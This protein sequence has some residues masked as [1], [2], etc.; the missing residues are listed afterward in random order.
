MSSEGFDFKKFISD[1]TDTVLKPKE[2][3]ESMKTNGG[4]AEPL[5]K[6]LIYGV[7]AGFIYLIWGFL[8]FGPGLGLFGGAV[9]IMG[10]IW[11]I[12]GS[13]IGLFI[14]AVIILVL[15]AIARGNTDFEACVRVSASIM[16][17]LPVIAVC[18]VLGAI[19]FKLSSLVMLLIN[20]YGLWLLFNGLV[21]T[22]KADRNTTKIITIVLV[23]LLALAV[24]AGM[25]A[26]RTVRNLERDAKKMEKIYKDMMKDYKDN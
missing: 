14:A 10:L 5:I 23:A 13:I 2:Y 7:V 26:R 6:A 24:L 12:V 21:I 8:K 20:I 3:F 16:V 1:S 22:L 4:L 9:G 11:T 25:T 15:S 19:S 18:S 17:L